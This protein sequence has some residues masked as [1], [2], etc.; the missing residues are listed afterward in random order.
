MIGT[1]EP[2][3]ILRR[4][5]TRV[6]LAGMTSVMLA[7][8]GLLFAIVRVSNQTLMA[9]AVQTPKPDYPPVAKNQKAQGQVEVDVVVT[10][11]GTVKDAQVVSGH[12]LLRD[13]AKATAMKW[14]FDP[15]KLHNEQD[16]IG[17][18]VF[19]FKL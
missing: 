19:N 3:S 17:T 15:A 6:V 1:R 11:D 18:I 4:R 9:A 13:T 2:R 8:P 16:V 5:W 7:G 10:P 12:L 14:K